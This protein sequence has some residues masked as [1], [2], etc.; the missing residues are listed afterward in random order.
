MH[1]AGREV[2]DVDVALGVH[3]ALPADL[4]DPRHVQGVVPLRGGPDVVERGGTGREA[5]TGVSVHF[6]SNL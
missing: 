1:D 3:L 6:R 4:G 2:R 5:Q